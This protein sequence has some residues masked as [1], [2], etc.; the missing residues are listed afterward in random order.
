LIPYLVRVSQAFELSIVMTGTVFF[1]IGSAK[2][3]WSTIA[4][5]RSGIATLLVGA[6]AAAIAYGA[7]WF[8]KG[9][10]VRF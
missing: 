8:L 4:W 3:K 2:S 1:C 5:W 7:G 9:L 6:I 10:L